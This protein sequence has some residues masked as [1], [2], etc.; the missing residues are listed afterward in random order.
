MR[1]IQHSVKSVLKM[2][3]VIGVAVSL[4]SCDA[5]AEKR[6]IL[7][8]NG[9]WQVTSSL[10]TL[11]PSNF[12]SK[13]Q[14]P[15]LMDMARPA[16]DSSGYVSSKRNYFWYRKT[17]NLS[18]DK[19]DFAYLKIHKAKYGHAVYI[20]GNYVGKYD[21]CFTPSYFE[22]SKYLKND[23]PNEIIVRVGASAEVLPDTI[24]SGYDQER[25]IY[26]P[27]I[28]DNVELY[29][30][31]YPYIENIQ[32]APDIHNKK[33]LA[34]VY[35]ENDINESASKI[36]YVVKEKKSGKI[37][38]QGYSDLVKFKKNEKSTLK[39]EI[40]IP[41]CQL[42]SPESPFLYELTI[43]SAGDTKKTTFGMREFKFDQEKKLALLNGK[44]YYLRGTNVAV[45]RF[46]EDE[47]RGG[48]PWN[49][50]WIEKMHDK[51]KEMYWNSHRFHIGFAPD[52]WYDVADEKGF[53]VQ[54]EYAV[55][56]VRSP[57]EKKKHSASVLAKEYRAWMKERWNHPSVVIWDAQNETVWGEIGK[58]IEMVRD[59]DLSDRPW[60]NGYS[61]PQSPKDVI[62]SHPYMF[63]KENQGT[64]AIMPPW[65]YD[66]AKV[67][68]HLPEG[69]WLKNELA[70][71]PEL[72]NDANDK[73]P[74]PDGKDYP[75]AY[76]I[77]EYGWIWLYRNG[78]PAWIAE[79][80]WRYYPEYDTPEKRFEWRA[81]VIAAKTEYW[82]SRRD[83]AGIMHHCA[84]TF[85]RPTEPRSTLS[86]DWQDVEKLIFQP[87][88][89]KYAKS[90]F[91]PVGIMIEKWDDQ[92]KPG[93]ELTIP[94]VLF[95]DL[96]DDWQGE[97][98][99]KLLQEGKII[100]TKKQNAK[101]ES[102]KR[103]TINFDIKIP[104]L[105]TNYEMIA[106][107]NLDGEAIFST[108]IFKVRK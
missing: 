8:L 37:V 19:Y 4:T 101:V 39:L 40:D 1:F 3:L 18:F 91:A 28:Y 97:V 32:V 24:P 103:S 63:V 49:R 57:K 96:Y 88:F 30:G 12:P 100:E 48:L 81:R 52:D 20:N 46:F 36:N 22:V 6:E 72:F 34:V 42:W 82:R 67:F 35:L 60:E 16:F 14:V 92:F 54:D 78:T 17:V 13:I 41:S 87:M 74:S 70:I 65:R 107:F 56:G 31:K 75:N 80:A 66:P 84:L 5:E 45:Q 68:P 94:V 9:E 25:Y 93:E 62:E 105:E 51:F 89:K 58:A 33:I 2:L 108:R 83:I 26:Y 106:E 99:F 71:T 73:D 86:D 85:D 15:G 27:G 21:F 50:E 10:D 44:P 59:L 43:N 77:N 90:A 79:E 47:L 11:V 53:L 69:G 7:S 38:N 55:W 64:F 29:T 61:A 98:T 104:T 23:A 95:N 76:I 102:L